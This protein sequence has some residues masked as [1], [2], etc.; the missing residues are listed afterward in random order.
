MK[1]NVMYLYPAPTFYP[2]TNSTNGSYTGGYVYKKRC[3]HF[4][5]F[6]KYRRI[7]K[8]DREHEKK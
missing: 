7:C 5:L 4:C 2:S 6:C 8:A 3:K 1:H